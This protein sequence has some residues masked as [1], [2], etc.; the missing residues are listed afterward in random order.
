MIVFLNDGLF[1]V[2][3]PVES[4]PGMAAKALHKAPKVLP[5]SLL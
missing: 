5:P 2:G 3:L 1:V 4:T